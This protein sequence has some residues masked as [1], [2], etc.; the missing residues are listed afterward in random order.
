MLGKPSGPRIGSFVS[1][2]GGERITEII[3]RNRL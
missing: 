1:Q 2:M 3:Q